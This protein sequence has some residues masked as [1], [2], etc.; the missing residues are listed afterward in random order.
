M[1]TINT[2]NDS[3]CI[4][5]KKYKVLVI[6]DDDEIREYLALCLQVDYQVLEAN[7]GAQGINMAR[8]SIPDLIISDIQMPEMDGLEVVMDLK[9]DT[10]TNHVPVVLLTA[11]TEQADEFQGIEKG[12]DVYMEKPFDI[13]LLKAKVKSLIK[14]RED[15]RRKFQNEMLMSPSEVEIPSADSEFIQKAIA[16]IEENMEDESFGVEELATEIGM[17]RSQLYRKLWSITNHSVNDFIRTI[18]LK[19]AAQLLGNNSHTVQEA[20]LS[21]GFANASYFSKCFE[22]QFGVLPSEYLASKKKK[23]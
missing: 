9:S 10:T 20:R 2:S 11:Y 13:N 1:G 4:D 14:S 3:A 16:I 23:Q 5:E 22:K 17:S 15:L 7:N 8:V 19:R 21:V 12:A 18:R 6:D